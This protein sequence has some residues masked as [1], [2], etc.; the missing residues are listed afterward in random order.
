MLSL[1]SDLIT[2]VAL[3]HYNILSQIIRLVLCQT[4][5]DVTSESRRKYS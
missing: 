4:R 3:Q 2:L 1:L 5:T